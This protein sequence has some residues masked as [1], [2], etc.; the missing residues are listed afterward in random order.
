MAMVEIADF[1]G[2][3]KTVSQSPPVE[4]D[5]LAGLCAMQRWGRI[6]AEHY[7]L[8][9]GLGY[10]ASLRSLKKHIDKG[11]VG[12]IRA[13]RPNISGVGMKL[14]GLSKAGYEF[15]HCEDPSIDERRIPVKVMHHAGK[16]LHRMDIIAALLS[17]RAQLAGSGVF[18]ESEAAD[19]N[20]R[21]SRTS[22]AA[23]VLAAGKANLIPD[24]ILDTEDDAG[25]RA[26]YLI[27]VDRGTEQITSNV[28]NRKTLLGMFASYW[29][30]LESADDAFRH[31][32]LVTVP[33]EKR[34]QRIL[35]EIPWSEMRPINGWGPD[36]FFRVAVFSQAVGVSRANTKRVRGNFWGPVWKRPLVDGDVPL[37][38]A[39]VQED[40]A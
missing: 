31:R 37:L 2:S 35:S 24:A 34:R 11:F 28:P 14:F 10:D 17:A 4:S 23:T 5:P 25:N 21:R 16:F 12:M 29:R 20:S 8:A 19:F 32:V 18:I 3:R 6:S 1:F 15:L 36:R 7:A 22:G 13:T 9:R 38:R 30:F 40:A 33:D 39:P 26:R 27:E